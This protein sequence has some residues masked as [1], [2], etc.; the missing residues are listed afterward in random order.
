MVLA[1]DLT[2]NKPNYDKF[3]SDDRGVCAAEVVDVVYRF[4]AVV[5]RHV[6]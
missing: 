6:Q 4:H 3:Y 5:R 1:D 2:T